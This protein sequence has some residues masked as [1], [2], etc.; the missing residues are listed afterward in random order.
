MAILGRCCHLL[1]F[2]VFILSQASGFVVE[3]N[4]EENF[5]VEENPQ[6]KVE[7]EPDCFI[8]QLLVGSFL[9]LP[10]CIFYISIL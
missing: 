2:L 6:E 5:V 9:S 10:L 4:S 8:C 7:K 1:V 3:E